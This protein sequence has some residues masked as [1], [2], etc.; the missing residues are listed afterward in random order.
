MRRIHL[1]ELEDQPWFPALLRNYMTDLLQFQLETFRVYAPAV[2][3]L[4]QALEVT[5]QRRIVD[6]CSGGGG[7]IRSVQA[8]LAREGLTVPVTLSDLFP[9]TDAFRRVARD[10]AGP[11]SFREEPVDA[12]RVPEDLQGFRTMFSC[13]HHFRPEAVRAILV[14]A[15]RCRT[16]IGIF[17]L[18]ERSA[19]GVLS[20]FPS[21]LAAFAMTPLLRPF[22]WSRIALTYGVPVV[23]LGF[24]VDG[25]M[26][27]LRAY[28]LPELRELVASV[29]AP[30]YH[31]EVAS[32]EHRA[33]PMRVTAVLG[34]PAEPV[35]EGPV[36]E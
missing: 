24:L 6:L 9:N 23:P 2:P 12:T 34:H 5:C 21:P 10:A 7:P 18:V 31:W 11:V 29:D 36:T 28:P 25:V 32:I 22:R 30:D 35:R 33:L 15:V 14:D 8:Q 13:L 3:L 1:F 4:R 26:S 20:V 19:R 16:G 27:H 17:D